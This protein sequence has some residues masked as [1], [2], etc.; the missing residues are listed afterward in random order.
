MQKKVSHIA[1]E[2]QEG[3][4]ITIF[5]FFLVISLMGQWDVIVGT[6]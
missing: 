1:I 4:K 6:W 3:V 2:Q 5:F